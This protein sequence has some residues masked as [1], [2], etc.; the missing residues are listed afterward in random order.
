MKEIHLTI[1]NSKL[2]VVWTK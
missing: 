1:R 2:Y